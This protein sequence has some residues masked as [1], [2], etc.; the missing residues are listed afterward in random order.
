[1]KP[2]LIVF[3]VFSCFSAEAQYTRFIIEFKDKNE[4]NHAISNPSTFLSPE[5]IKRK[6]MFNIEIDSTDLPVSKKY[7]D[8]ISSFPDIKLIYTSRWMNFALIQTANKNSLNKIN[9]LG[10]V[11]NQFPIAN[12]PVPLKVKEIKN[13]VLGNNLNQMQ[14]TSSENVIP[15]GK[16]QSQIFIHEGEYLH[17]KGFFGDGIKIALFDAGF[18]RFTNLSAFDSLKNQN[19]FKDSWDFVSNE[20]SVTDDDQHGTK[21]LS[22]MGANLPGIFVGSSPH[23][24]YYLYRTE[25]AETEYPIEEVY[26]LIAAERADSL[27]VDMISSSLG[28]TVFTDP[29]FNHRFSNLNGTE[30]IVSKA[31]SMAVSKGM[32]VMNSAGNEGG[33]PWK[34][35]SAPADGI[36]VLAVGAINTAKQLA[37]FSGIGPTADGRIKP[38]IVSVGVNTQLIESDGTV[39]SGNG[40][41]FSNPNIAGLVACLWQ[42]FYDFSN[43]E[44]IQA[45]KNSADQFLSPDNLKGYGIPNLHKAYSDLYHQRAIRLSKKIL[46]EK[47]P[48]IF[49]NPIIEVGNIAYK[50]TSEGIF[51]WKLINL[52]GQVFRSGTLNVKKDEYYVIELR[53]LE[54]VSKGNYFLIYQNGEEH[55]VLP[56]IK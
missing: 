13:T 1:M 51:Q 20:A 45:I 7:I 22:I 31:A 39:G 56:F 25:D 54:H 29:Y 28:Y 32:I 9:A 38:D 48:Q 8:S 17:S 10:F 27:G 40:T 47:N 41:S 2:L 53:N 15:Y 35:I 34:Y 46:T 44:I 36:H 42:A 50:S 19:K 23:A 6:K 24:T 12:I 11:K 33:R 30:T 49:P 37:E 16:S 43:L 26:W 3:G 14:G 4:T 5:S 18:Y 55:G 52:Y 21:C